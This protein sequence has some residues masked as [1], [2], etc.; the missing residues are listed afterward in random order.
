MAAR[1]SPRPAPRRFS[2]G[3]WTE[4]FETLADVCQGG[5]QHIVILDEFYY[6]VQSESALPSA[7]QNAWDHL[8]D[9]LEQRIAEQLRTFNGSDAGVCR[10]TRNAPSGSDS[11]G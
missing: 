2:Y 7:L 1:Q 3:S 4:A 8:Y 5:K 10:Q 9:V 11:V 6:A